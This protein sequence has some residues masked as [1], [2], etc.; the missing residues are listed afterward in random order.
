MA[1]MAIAVIVSIVSAA[2]APIDSAIAFV[3]GSKE[4]ESLS[5]IKGDLEEKNFD[6]EKI[7][8]SPERLQQCID[9][10]GADTRSMGATVEGLGKGIDSQFTVDYT[11]YVASFVTAPQTEDE[12]NPIDTPPSEEQQSPQDEELTIAPSEEEQAPITPSLEDVE[13]SAPPESTAPADPS[14]EKVSA[15][16][17]AALWKKSPVHG[18]QYLNI[19]RPGMSPQ[20]SKLIYA[21]AQRAVATSGYHSS[22]EAP[23]A[24]HIAKLCGQQLGKK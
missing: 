8:V 9:S 5:K 7:G 24:Y 22:Y 15:E 6:V 13:H 11:A 21:L 3:T 23:D 1:V 16:E 17:Y 14:V 4:E 19:M 10:M 18:F 20:T 12:K 2:M